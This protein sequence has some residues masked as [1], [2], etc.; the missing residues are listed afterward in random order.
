MLDG[1][2]G[3]KDPVG[4]SGVRLEVKVHIVTGADR[5]CRTCSNAVKGQG[6]KLLILCLS[7]L[8]LQEAVLT[9]DEKDLGVALI[10]IGGG[11][12]DI[13]IYRDGSLR[14]TAVLALAAIISQATLVSA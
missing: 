12:T 2:D 4:M 9:D 6:L 8:H 11:T 10:D 3:I 1:Q 13:A 14:H 5:L 7:P